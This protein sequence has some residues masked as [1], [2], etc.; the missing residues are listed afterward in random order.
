MFARRAALMIRIAKNVAEADAAKT[1]EEFWASQGSKKVKSPVTGQDVQLNTLRTYTDGPGAEQ[2]AQILDREFEAWKGAGK[3]SGLP[4]DPGEG[5]SSQPP[6]KQETPVQ[7]YNKALATYNRSSARLK[8]IES[9]VA[10]LEDIGEQIKQL[11]DELESKSGSKAEAIRSQIKELTETRKSKAGV[12]TEFDTLTKAVKEAEATMKDTKPERDKLFQEAA[13]KVSES[14]EWPRGWA[15][16]GGDA[17]A[18]TTVS[19]SAVAAS[20]D[21]LREFIAQAEENGLDVVKIGVKDLEDPDDV[22]WPE[23]TKAFGDVSTASAYVAM[24]MLRN[25]P[26]LQLDKIDWLDVPATRKL[27]ELTGLDFSDDLVGED[28]ERFNQMYDENPV[29]EEIDTYFEAKASQALVDKIHD[30]ERKGAVVMA[31]VPERMVK[32]IG[33][34][35]KNSKRVN[36]TPDKVQGNLK[37]LSERKHRTMLEAEDNLKRLRQDLRE[38]KRNGQPAQDIEQ[39]IEEAQTAFQSARKDLGK[40][41]RK[42]RTMEE[43]SEANK[44]TDKLNALTKRLENAPESE[45]KSIQKE[46]DSVKSAAASRYKAKI[47][48]M[49]MSMGVEEDS[50]LDDAYDLLMFFAMDN[51]E[52][53][54][55]VLEDDQKRSL[56]QLIDEAF[57]TGEESEDL[58]S[59]APSKSEKKPEKK[60]PANDQDEIENHPA[61][62]AAREAVESIESMIGRL[63]DGDLNTVIENLSEALA[64]MQPNAKMPED[65]RPFIEQLNDLLGNDLHPNTRLF[66]VNPSTGKLEVAGKVWNQPGKNWNEISRMIPKLLEEAIRKDPKVKVKYD[67]LNEAREKARK[68]LAG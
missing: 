6:A 13:K 46:I 61:V 11:Q 55:L 59:P 49:L 30:A 42:I 57:G 25:N 58:G 19:G 1:W 21:D 15:S 44:Y 18:K 48:T 68:E 47:D 14:V 31:A 9:E 22:E 29:S 35:I 17:S 45:R 23:L 3:P 62:E 12:R 10:E 41:L 52:I 39:Q 43:E 63:V 36:T 50:P 37:T 40:T 26:K 8:E 16:D 67:K 5:S 54:K 4:T 32:G 28:R 51:A 38:A 27:E 53:R 33:P 66:Y 64:N 65:A 60:Q 7:R 2:A 34:A 20:E 56:N 24:R